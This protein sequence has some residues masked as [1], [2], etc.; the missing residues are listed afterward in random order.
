M[1]M[2]RKC[3]AAVVALM[4]VVGGLFAEEIKGVFKKFEDGKVTISVEEKDK[5]FTVDKEAKVKLKKEDVLLTDYLGKWKDGDKGTFTVDGDEADEGEERKEITW[6]DTIQSR[7]LRPFA[8]FVR[9]R[10]LR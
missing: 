2:L 6:F 10:Y 1:Q 5:T 8:G 9:F 3:F 7:S 4:L